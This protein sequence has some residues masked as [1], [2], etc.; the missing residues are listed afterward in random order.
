MTRKIF[1]SVLRCGVGLGLLAS[2]AGC[3]DQQEPVNRVQ[4][5]ALDKHFF[6]G[7][8]LSNATD[9]PEFYWRGY[10][11]DGSAAQSAIG[12]GS[13]SH[14]DRIRWEVTEDMLIARKAY[15]LFDQSDQDVPPDTYAGTDSDGAVVAIYRITSHFDI[16]RAY[17]AQT[18][19]EMNVIEENTTDRPWNEREFMRVDWSTNQVNDPMWMDMFMGKVFGDIKLTSLVYNVTDPFHKDAPHFE[20]E[21]GYFDITNRF[22]LEPAESPTPW[23]FS[24]WGCY[25][26]GI[27]NG[28]ATNGC[29]PQEATVRFSYKKVDPNN[30]FEPLE[31]TKSYMEVVGNPGGLGN[32]YSVGVVTAPRVGYDSWYGFTDKNMKRL[33][34]IHNT[35]KRSHQDF[36]CSAKYDDDRNGTDDQCENGVTGYVGASGSQC[37]TIV[38]KCT[39]P[40]RDR[41]IKTVGYWV[42]DLM[43][44]EFQDP[45]DPATGQPTGRGANEDIVYSWN[46]MMSNAVAY[47]REVECRRTGEG[48]RN[49]CHGQ[50]FAPEKEMVSYGGWLT[51]KALDPTPVVTLCHNPV[52]SYDIHDV[53]GDEGYVVR[54]GDIRR[55]MLTYWPYDSAAPWG[56]IAN[57][58]GDPL[59]GEIMGG[60]ALVMGRS[61]RYGAAWARDVLQVAMGD[62]S[63][64]DIITGVPQDIYFSPN[65][66]TPGQKTM[67]LTKDEIDHRTTAVDAQHLMQFGGLKPLQGNTLGEKLSAYSHMRASMTF[68]PTAEAADAAAFSNLVSPLLNTKFETDLMTPSMV[69]NTV[70]S[71]GSVSADE[72]PM[73]SPLRMLDPG[74]LR[75]LT[76]SIR[77]RLEARGAC[78]LEHEAP[79]AGSV[80]IPGLAEHYKAKYADLDPVARGEAIYNEL[81]VETYKGI[82]IHEMGHSLGMLHQFASSWDST[83]Y[84]P[85]Y[86][87]LR[88]GGG[89]TAT[90]AS[91]NGEVRDPN[92]P[93]TC[94]GPRY[95]DGETPD[96]MGL[97][98]ESRPGLNY[99]ASTS[100]MEYQWERFG[101][102]AGLGTY[103][104]HAMKALYGRVLETIDESTMPVSE[105]VRFAPRMRSQLNESEDII[106]VAPTKFGNGPQPVHYT[107]L[108]R[109]MKIF[110][111][112]RDC[113]PA[114]AE[115]KAKA[116]WRIVHDLVCAPAPRDHAAWQ[117]FI[118][119]YTVPG[120]ATSAA[121]YW[122]TADGRVRWFHRFGSTSNA[123][124]H[125]NPSDAGADPY[126]AAVNA[127]RKFE[128]RYAW[129]YFR[130]K[131]REFNFLFMPWAISRHYFDLE[132]TYNWHATSRAGQYYASFPG[133]Y[134]EMAK[135][136][137]WLRPYLMAS[138]ESFNMLAGAVMSPQPGP[139]YPSTERKITG[140]QKSTIFDFDDYPSDMAIK[141]FDI[142][143]GDGRF[144]D[145]DMN[146]SPEGGG[147]WDYQNWM[148]RVGYE[149]EKSLAVAMLTDGRPPVYTPNREMF[150][151]SR[152]QRLS[153][154]ASMPHAID[155]LIGG[156]LSEDWEA[157]APSYEC[158]GTDPL[159]KQCNAGGVKLFDLTQ[160][161][162]V[163]PRTAKEQIM[164]PNIGF[165]QQSMVGIYA[166]IYSRHTGDMTL[167]NKMRIWIDGVDGTVGTTGFPNPDEQVRFYNPMSGMTYIAR[168]YGREELRKEG[169]AT[170]LKTYDTGVGARM[171]EFANW[172]M[173]YTYKVDRDPSNGQPIFDEFGQVN[174]LLDAEGQ[175]QLYSSDPA[176]TKL[177]TLIN[178]AGHIDG[179][180]QIGL[181]LGA[182]PLN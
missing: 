140:Y 75:I 158:T 144:I 49:G 179:V 50:Y 3:A 109:Q 59:T 10:V 148:N 82:A 157:I 18:G 22:Y 182:G 34:N 119:D 168:R 72:L 147:S 56:G 85:Q 141:A 159:T 143:L 123:Y 35:W 86:W 77:T 76:D 48:D 142:A 55:N 84:T 92:G 178:Y 4:A 165:Q 104:Q 28:T 61:V 26:E 136:D 30:D 66:V 20:P 155:R 47:A 114:T 16:R 116:D 93:D 87:Q 25:L 166:A 19:E 112:A 54:T 24:I 132:R 110:D 44:D 102:S 135:S 134:E 149:V 117:D 173:A 171:L 83:N 90:T 74:K 11:V 70:G 2:I 8:S 36:G 100:T 57:W 89:A 164:F 21:D 58:N 73:V 63:I 78:F 138:T 14:V 95:L 161:D 53:C 99:F 67:A 7:E 169:L 5:N 40:Y 45:I 118:S 115:E 39:I 175:P 41:E 128:A 98:D 106:P 12:V 17:N 125:T 163:P 1:K 174:L 126:E 146:S 111:A 156:L 80:D 32:S 160:P 152:S 153:F 133:Q 62:L 122:H 46:Q 23:G 145:D 181:I 105:Q 42:N 139:Y 121:P 151:D 107:E 150:L 69:R 127:R 113:R 79:L 180:R 131:S 43:P 52:R 170:P 130:R 29:E 88:T 176:N 6:L 101:E 137:D 120:D 96:E 129:S 172:I 64:Q 162:G 60:A 15:P 177:S 108:A 31:N 38:E 97:A 91:C 71:D 81:V 124:M 167:L 13:W 68:D 33:A 94:M 154:Y 9:D 37:D 103:D 27:F 51:D 65:I